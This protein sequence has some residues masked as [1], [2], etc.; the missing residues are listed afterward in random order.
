LSEIA[1]A[2]VDYA[3][4]TGEGTEWCRLRCAYVMAGTLWHRLTEAEAVERFPPDGKVYWFGPGDVR[5]GSVWCVTCSPNPN[6]GEDKKRDKYIVQEGASVPAFVTIPPE[7]VTRTQVDDVALRRAV[8]SGSLSFPIAPIGPVYLKVPSSDSHWIGPMSISHSRNEDGRYHLASHAVEGFLAVYDVSTEHLQHLRVT[9][10]EL[11]TLTPQG[12][13][14]GPIALFNVQS[15]DQ[16][17]DGALKRIRKMDRR[18]ADSLNVTKALLHQH[19]ATLRDAEL[20]GDQ[21]QHEAARAEALKLLLKGIEFSSDQVDSIARA[22]LALPTMSERLDQAIGATIEERANEIR[23][24]A[25]SRE[26]EALARASEAEGALSRLEQENAGLTA[27]VSAL[28]LQAEEAKAELRGAPEQMAL[29]IEEVLQAFR[30]NPTQYLGRSL[31]AQTLVSRFMRAQDMSPREPALQEPQ[32]KLAALPQLVDACKLHAAHHLVDHEAVLAAA[33][34]ALPMRPVALIGPAADAVATVLASVLAGGNLVRFPVPSSVF[35][36]EDMLELRSV[37]P[38]EARFGARLGDILH[39]KAP[40]PFLALLAGVDRAPLEVALGDL[41]RPEIY[42]GLSRPREPP[43]A[44]SSWRGLIATMMPGPSTFR[45]PQSLRAHL[46]IV[47]CDWIPSESV[48]M[49]RTPPTTGLTSGIGFDL[50]GVAIPPTVREA[51]IEA[52]ISPGVAQ[53]E[54]NLLTACFAESER[55]LVWWSL[56]RLAGPVSA[57]ALRQLIA[58]CGASKQFDSMSKRVRHLYAVLETE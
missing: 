2:V 37:D 34:F 28:K 1:I 7:D 4:T 46:P 41:V 31:V 45:V 47:Y 39:L 12:T 54:I 38:N 51:L 27:Q 55:G 17:L 43:N 50:Q 19:M 40:M 53:S 35:G 6:A 36:L 24:A 13:L 33:A 49:P 16:L 11:I 14:S 58:A 9:H 8:A 20:A 5:K 23:R 3:R 57:S 25:E 52:G 44:K 32:V 42:P 56:G 29:A 22:L 48:E 30:G 15:D 26:S 10:H 21:G 18:V